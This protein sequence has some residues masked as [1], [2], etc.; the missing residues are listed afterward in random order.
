M[1]GHTPDPAL[2]AL[3]R[4]A[5]SGDRRALEE[6]LV[7]HLPD[8]RAYVR[9]RM[10]PG[11]RARER[12]SDLLQTVC[13]EV[14]ESA[15]N[16]R[17]EG[18][19]AFKAWLYTAVLR[20]LCDRDAFWR[21][22]RRDAGREDALDEEELLGSYRR[23]A[24]PSQ[25]AVA[26]DELRRVEAAF[27]RLPDDYREV[28]LLSRVAGLP[29]AAVADEMDRTEASVRNLLHRALALLAKEIDEGPT[30]G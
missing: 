24:S 12:E 13:R 8:V 6:L 25:A 20:K 19:G 15:D 17:F 18:E 11:L 10:G 21:A 7:R 5:S 30:V 2:D 26:G 14:L 9:L 27:A 16:F 3:H 29:R 1:T 4:A 22:E 23:F 28:I